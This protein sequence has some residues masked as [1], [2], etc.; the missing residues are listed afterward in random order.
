MSVN[1]YS[2][3]VCQNWTPESNKGAFE[4]LQVTEFLLEGPS[5][6]GSQCWVTVRWLLSRHVLLDCDP[7]SQTHR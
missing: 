4:S 6:E 7:F 3:S 5:H 2:N 1:S